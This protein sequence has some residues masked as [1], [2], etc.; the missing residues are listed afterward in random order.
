MTTPPDTLDEGTVGTTKGTDVIDTISVVSTDIAAAE[1][2]DGVVESGSASV[3]VTGLE[4][5]VGPSLEATVIVETSRVDELIIA[6]VIEGDAD[7]DGVSEEEG[8]I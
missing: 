6:D 1:V 8:G 3:V 4:E 5:L 7:A 2:D